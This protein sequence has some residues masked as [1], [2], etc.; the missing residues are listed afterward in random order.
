MQMTGLEAKDAGTAADDNMPVFASI[1]IGWVTF[2]GKRFASRS[3][4]K[5]VYYRLIPEGMRA[6]LEENP[7]VRQ[8]L[9]STET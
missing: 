2:E 3:M 1:G 8:V 7:H 6:K 9:L 5:G 4:T